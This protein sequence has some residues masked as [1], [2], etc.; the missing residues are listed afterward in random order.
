MCDKQRWH[1]RLVHADADPIARY[2]RLCYFKYRLTNA[3]AVTDADLVISEFLNSEVL[4]ELAK[5]K[6][7]APQKPFP[8]SVGIHLVDKYGALLPSVTGEIPLCITINVELAYH[9]PPFDRKF[10]DRGSD[11]LAIPT[12]FAWKTD[13]Y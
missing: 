7:A 4:A 11:S 12:H 9:P 3:V 5:T 1:T 10:P 2:A 8:I 6:V 13:I